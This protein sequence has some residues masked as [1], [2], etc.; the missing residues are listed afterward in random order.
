M[1][2]WIIDRY[3]AG[4]DKWL[5]GIDTYENIKV[6]G[7]N[8]GHY[9]FKNGGIVMLYDLLFNPRWG[10]AK[11]FWGDWECI[12]EPHSNL[13]VPIRFETPRQTGSG[14][15][16]DKFQSMAMVIEDDPLAYL[17]QFK[18]VTA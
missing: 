5:S 3:N 17:E 11:A 16:I 13:I 9:L 7:T 4:Q 12:V 6:I 18:E 8:L 15:T 14:Q 10:F 2:Q 1:N